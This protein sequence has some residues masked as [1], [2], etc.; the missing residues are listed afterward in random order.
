MCFVTIDFIVPNCAYSSGTV[1]VLSGDEIYMDYYSVLGPIDPQ[2]ESEN[3][4]FVS[5]L[6]YLAKFEELSRTIN[7]A[8]SP[9]AV[10]A[11]LAYLLK[12]FDPAE[13]FDLDQVRK[14][15]EELLTE[16]L[17][18]HKFKSWTETESTKTTVDDAYR[19]AP[20]K[21][22]AETLGRPERWHSHGRGIGLKELSSEEIKLKI[23]DF[24]L[25]PE[26]NGRIRPYYE[27]F[28]DYCKKMGANT[29]NHTVI[30]TRNGV[31]RV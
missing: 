30:H 13:L 29:P 18:K 26:L 3:E 16:W 24:G 10:R 19:R 6:G 21:A 9:D 31:R 15:S 14:H 17:S 11:E 7:A 4:R 27:L 1:L 22:I 2:M 23:V 8:P 28:I 12:K 5:G 20:A 25:K